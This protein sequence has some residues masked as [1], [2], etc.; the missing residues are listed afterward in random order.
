MELIKDFV[1]INWIIVVAT[2][3]VVIIATSI[4]INLLSYF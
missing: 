2:V 3:T 4:C 1:I